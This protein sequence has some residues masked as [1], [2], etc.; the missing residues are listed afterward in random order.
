MTAADFPPN[1]SV[2]G[3]SSRPQVLAT[4]R[5]AQVDPVNDTVST[6]ALATSARPTSAPPGTTLNTPAGTPAFAAT[7]ASS[8]PSSGVSGDGLSTTVQPAAN[9]G[10]YLNAAWVCGTFHGVTAATTPTGTYDTRVRVPTGVC[11]VSP[12]GSC[13]IR[14]A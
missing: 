13:S 11:L 3:R 9:A 10:T 12:T 2:T 14:P 6:P 8:S 7:S 5:P 4:S 1:S